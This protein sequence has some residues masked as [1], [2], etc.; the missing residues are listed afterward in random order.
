MDEH[1]GRES[2]GRGR[3]RDVAQLRGPARASAS[4][5]VI[6]GTTAEVLDSL[7]LGPYPGTAMPGEEGN[8]A[9]A[10]HRQTDGAVLDHIDAL[11]EGD[12][13]H[14]RTADGYYT[15]LYSEA[16]I[17]L[18]TQTDVIAPVPGEPGAPADGRYMT[19]TSCHPRFGD[20]ERII[21][22]AELESWRRTPPA[23][24]PRS[25]TSSSA[26]PTACETGE[27]MDASPSSRQ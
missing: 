7:G 26:T 20:T 9:V 6:V 27:H 22:H 4:R 3:G 24:H 1:R 18:P 2:P 23:R 10:G 17:V 19:L 15:Y 16:Q 12:R 8:F 5:P 21:V 11:Q 13:I 25:P 14:V